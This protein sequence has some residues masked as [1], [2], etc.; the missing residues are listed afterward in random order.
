MG[1]N[2]Y[3]QQIVEDMLALP[4]DKI[5]EVADFV[6]LPKAQVQTSGHTPL[7]ETGLTR[8]EAFDLRRRLAAFENDRD[9]PGMGAY[10]GL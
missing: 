5:V 3:T 4:G 2:E 1:A 7:R 6:H 8:E 10:D 9:A